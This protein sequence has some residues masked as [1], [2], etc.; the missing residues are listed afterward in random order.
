MLCICS[1]LVYFTCDYVPC[2][3]WHVRAYEFC[4]SIVGEGQNPERALA[5]LKRDSEGMKE[6]IL[7]GLLEDQ[8]RAIKVGIRVKNSLQKVRGYGMSDVS[9][10]HYTEEQSVVSS[11]E[12]DGAGAGVDAVAGAEKK[13][14]AAHKMTHN[15][16]DVV[17]VFFSY[18]R[19]VD[20]LSIRWRHYAVVKF[21]CQGTNAK[22]MLCPKRNWK[23]PK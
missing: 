22:S 23:R 11:V 19:P 18:C 15:A 10:S 9:S 14:K 17:K 12:N 13:Q 3:V 20:H 16:A 6:K 1:L 8:I 4:F 21:R 2:I 7:K 5:Q